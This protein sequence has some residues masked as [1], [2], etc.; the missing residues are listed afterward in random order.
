M[1]LSNSTGLKTIMV[2]TG[3]GL[4]EFTYQKKSWKKN[5]DFICDNLLEAAQFISKNELQINN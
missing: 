2:M 5:P 1:Q 3:Y 4:G